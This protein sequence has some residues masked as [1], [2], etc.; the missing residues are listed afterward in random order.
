MRYFWSRLYTDSAWDFSRVSLNH[1]NRTMI[2]IPY[3]NELQHT[4]T[5]FNIVSPWNSRKIN[6]WQNS[7]C[8][9]DWYIMVH[10]RPHSTCNTFMT[11]TYYFLPHIVPL[12]IKELQCN[13]KNLKGSIYS[14]VTIFCTQ[15]PHKPQYNRYNTYGIV[16]ESSAFPLYFT[17]IVIDT[18][19][20]LMHLKIFMH[21]MTGTMR[22]HSY[23]AD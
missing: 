1:H 10:C 21:R 14:T 8:T 20:I 22:T 13:P 16:I 7:W 9:Q 3:I 5:C 18:L 17:R 2:Q 23:L 15:R 4:S 11:I 12:F 6:I 19:I